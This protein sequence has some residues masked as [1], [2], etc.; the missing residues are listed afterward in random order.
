MT[1]NIDNDR[2]Y[3]LVDEEV[4]KVADEAY[5]EDGTSLYDA[6]RLTDRDRSTIEKFFDDAF[7]EFA[8]RAF[9]V[10]QYVPVDDGQG[11]QHSDLRFYVPDF[12]SSMETTFF[13]EMDRYV[14]LYACAAL[15]RQRRPL[16]ADEYSERWK[17]AMEKA[18]RILKSRK[19][20]SISWR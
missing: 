20:P 6:V 4:S 14:S 15:F 10:V 19:N 11:G 16:L 8:Q 7:S 3:R 17:A 18:V 2:L 5:D 13:K 1:Y 12:D 9:D